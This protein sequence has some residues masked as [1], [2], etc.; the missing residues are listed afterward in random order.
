MTSGGVYP[1]RT[2][3]A[4]L[5]MLTKN[6]AMDLAKYGIKAVTIHPGW[7]KTDMGGRN[8]EIEPQESIGGIIDLLKRDVSQEMS[9]AF[10]DYQGKV[11]DF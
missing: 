4:A 9:G 8:A 3:K 10:L 11:V 7:V 2:S 5:N 1:Y 6:F